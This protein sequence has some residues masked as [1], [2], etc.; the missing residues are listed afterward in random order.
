MEKEEYRIEAIG[1]V[2]SKV[3]YRYEAPRQGVLAADSESVIKLYAGKNYSQALKGLEGFSRIWVIYRFHLNDNWKP[4][5]T[6]PR[7]DGKK[8]GVFATRAPYRPNQ[9][10]ISCVKLLRIDKKNIYISESDIL[11]GSPVFDI[12]PYLPYSDSFPDAETGWVTTDMDKMFPVIFSADAKKQAEWLNKNAGI[13]LEGYASVQLSFNPFDTKRKRIKKLS[14]LSDEYLL[15]YRTWRILYQ[16]DNNDNK[17]TVTGVRSGY[18]KVEL[19]DNNY[20][21]YGD[22]ALHREFLAEDFFNK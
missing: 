8:I 4:L 21:K 9:I 15:A 20:D 17:V 2:R 1:Y 12:K 22:K 16:V 3:K 10:G 11:D 6:P 14:G 5:V 13:N 7:N 19:N 18:S